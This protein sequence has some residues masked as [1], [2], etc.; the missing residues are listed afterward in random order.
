MKM[1]LVPQQE[2]R[3]EEKITP[4]L[5]ELCE[6]S[7]ALRKMYFFDE[8]YEDIPANL[9]RDLL[10][11]KKNTPTIGVIHKFNSRVLFLLSYTCF[12]NCRFCERQDRVG[13]GLDH[14]GRLNTHQIDKG[15]S[16]IQNN[17]KI[18]EVIF[19]GGDPLTNPLGLLYAVEKLKDIEHV[20]IIR[21]HTKMPVQMPDKVN[22]DILQK[23]MESN[24]T[25]YLSIHINHPDE[26]NQITI[27][28]IN[29]IRK[30]GF[31]LL[32][33]SVFLKGINDNADTLFN[34]FNEL[35]CIGVRPYYIYHCQSIPTTDRFVMDISEERKIMT[36]L[37][38]RL[39]GVAFPNHVIDIQ[40]TTGKI[41]VPTDHWNEKTESI[42]DYQ[43]NSININEYK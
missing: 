29:K 4:Y 26:L 10:A 17:S 7:E 24:K 12:A 20:K 1:S 18:N 2:L 13:V 28:V 6:K 31:I 5:K 36:N 19:S 43:G 42:I 11:E 14:E 30:L 34:L 9:E 27:P 21:I 25:T 16:Y 32:S 41:I 8:E 22:Y 38:E 35:A 23:V 15:I 3:F 37:R 33:Q 40:G 39:S